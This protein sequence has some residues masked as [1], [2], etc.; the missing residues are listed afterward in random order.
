MPNYDYMSL[1]PDK[2]PYIRRAAVTFFQ[3]CLIEQLKDPSVP[4]T[5]RGSRALSLDVWEN[6]KLIKSL[7]VNMAA[8]KKLKTLALCG[9]RLSVASTRVLNSSIMS[10]KSLKSLKLNFMIYRT[11]ILKELLPCLTHS[12]GLVSIDLAANGLSDIHGPIIAKI[13][14]THQ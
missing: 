2:A 13:I 6:A 8:T 7:Q 14:Q 3:K 12:S 10:C 1:L 9:I 5:L 11:E 4:N